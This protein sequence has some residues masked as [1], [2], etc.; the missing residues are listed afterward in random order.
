MWCFI[1][2]PVTLP[3]DPRDP[4]IF[5]RANGADRQYGRSIDRIT[6][7]HLGPQYT[8]VCDRSTLPVFR[9]SALPRDFSH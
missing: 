5:S 9:P 6:L 3:D 8:L 1:C 2:D 4:L 7:I